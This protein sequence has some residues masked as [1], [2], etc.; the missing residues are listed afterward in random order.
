MLS[1]IVTFNLIIIESIM[2]AVRKLSDDV[3][4][5]MFINVQR[6]SAGGACHMIDAR[7]KANKAIYIYSASRGWILYPWTAPERYRKG[8]ERERRRENVAERRTAWLSIR[9][10]RN[11]PR[12]DSCV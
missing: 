2:C 8:R 11:I 10:N 6:R 9:K 12:I 3:T 5:N 7:H 4:R 1:F